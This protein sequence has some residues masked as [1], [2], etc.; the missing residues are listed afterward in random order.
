MA[1]IE[2]KATIKSEAREGKVEKLRILNRW[3]GWK[4]NLP[5]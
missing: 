2:A 4:A 5:K 1:N 3:R